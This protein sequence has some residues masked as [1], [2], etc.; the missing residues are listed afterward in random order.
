VVRRNASHLHYSVQEINIRW[1]VMSDSMSQNRMCI[2]VVEKDVVQVSTFTKLV[3]N[4]V[5][6]F[7]TKES[8]GKSNQSKIL[9]FF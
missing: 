8:E 3:L 1:R 7:Y 5:D 6:L 2:L 9:F 4:V